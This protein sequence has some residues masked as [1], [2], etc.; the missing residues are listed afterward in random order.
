MYSLTKYPG[1]FESNRS[2]LMAEI[3]S[4]RV[5]E[6]FGETVGEIDTFG[7]YAY[8]VGKRFAWILSED[9]QG[10]VD[11]ETFTDQA[12]AAKEWDKLELAYAD[13]CE[14]N[15]EETDY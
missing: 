9:S 10:F 4:N 1:K 6:G 5:N 8:V 3:V 14:Q 11:V 15:E 7:F 2:Q 13:F 12:Q